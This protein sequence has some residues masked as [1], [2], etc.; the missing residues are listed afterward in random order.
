M[1][2][3]YRMFLAFK[4]V[5]ILK[6]TDHPIKI[7][8]FALPSKILQ[9]NFSYPTY[10]VLLPLDTIWKTLEHHL[11]HAK[12]MM[13]NKSFYGVAQSSNVVF[14][15]FNHMKFCCVW[16]RGFLLLSLT[17]FY[18]LKTFSK[19]CHVFVTWSSTF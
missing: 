13:E 17:N 15:S 2:K 16:D 9:Q 1:L 14:H 7:N 3:I 19:Y 10:L 6:I 11:P 5:W 4:K 8:H 18:E 12:S